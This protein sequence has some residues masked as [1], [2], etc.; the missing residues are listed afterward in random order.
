M[1][2]TKNKRIILIKNKKNWGTFVARNL[3]VLVSKSKYVIIPDP[4]DI[5]S[6]N[7]IRICLKYGE[8]Y[9]YDI[10]K[11]NSYIGNGKLINNNFCKFQKIK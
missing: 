3:G 8:K 9:N 11:F 4:D 7:I 5:L 1:K 2:N 6:R 10:I